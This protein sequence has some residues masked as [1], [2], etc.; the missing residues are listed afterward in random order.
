MKSSLLV[1]FAWAVVL[2]VACGAAPAEPPRIGA[3]GR[4]RG[5][6]TWYG[7]RHHGR[8]TASGE[9]FDMYA[10]TAAHK[11]LPM[12][13]R[14]R[15]VNL[16][17]GRSVVVRINDRGPY[18]RGRIIDVSKAAARE[19]GMIDDGVVPVTVEVLPP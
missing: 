13:A 4:E 5:L 8:P 14:V 17:N 18:S 19:L 3:D 12:N 6:A 1:S 16:K 9:R 15:V 10:L 11:T 7:E 2:C